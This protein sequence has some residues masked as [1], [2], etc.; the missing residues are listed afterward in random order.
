MPGIPNRLPPTMMENSTPHAGYTDA[1]AHDPGRH[2]IAVKLLDADDQDNEQH[3]LDGIG[4]EQEHHAGM[5][6]MMGPK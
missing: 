3:R 6:P 4:K 2:D 1:A 5:A